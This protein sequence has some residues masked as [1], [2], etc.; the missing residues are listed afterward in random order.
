MEAKKLFYAIVILQM[1][2]LLGMIAFKQSTV[3]FGQ[4]VILKTEPFDPTNI[5]R[6]DY[7]NIRYDISTLDLSSFKNS[8]EFNR[9]DKIYVRLAKKGDVWD[10]EEIGKNRL[11]EPYLKG[12]INAVN[13]KIAY[14]IKELN[15]SKEYQ[16]E[17]FEYEGAYEQNY[18]MKVGDK[19]EF[20]FIGGM[21][22]YAYKCENNRC[23]GLKYK[24][25]LREGVITK[26]ARGKKE[27]S[28]DYP[29][30]AY[31]VPKNEGNL[32]QFTSGEMLVEVA[33]WKGDA[34]A[35]NLIINGQKIDFR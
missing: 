17:A 6:G 4:K 26:V 25:D 33:V 2:F 23:E 27:I 16:Y 8:P 15:S 21:I 34:V 9:G 32:P 31:F 12:I 28:I 14:S 11:Q 18:L 5:L 24:G 13:T 35:T 19:V 10:A 3:V 7:I 29:I 20:N 22:N 1:I 30:Q